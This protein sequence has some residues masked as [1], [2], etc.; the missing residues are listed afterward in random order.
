MKQFFFK[1]VMHVLKKKSLELLLEAVLAVSSTHGQC[2]IV[3]QLNG[4][5]NN[6]YLFSLSL[7]MVCQKVILSK[8]LSTD[9][10][11]GVKL[12]LGLVFTTNGA[13]YV[14]NYSQV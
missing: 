3:P 1:E 6:F 11:V 4:F 8:I 9:L 7:K 2:Q 14:Q 13:I 5:R 10:T 12:V